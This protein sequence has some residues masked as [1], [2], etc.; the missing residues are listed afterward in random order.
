MAPISEKEREERR[1]NLDKACMFW[2]RPA[3]TVLVKSI[4]KDWPNDPLRWDTDTTLLIRKLAS[5]A[6]D[7]GLEALNCILA[8][9]DRDE[10]GSGIRALHEVIKE[11]VDWLGDPRRNARLWPS[12]QPVKPRQKVP[13]NR[14]RRSN[15]AF[16]EFSLAQGGGGVATEV[17]LAERGG[18]S[19]KEGVGG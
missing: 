5:L 12:P 6:P 3:E 8:H 15:I 7:D 17:Y 11:I 18:Q 13:R 4:R 19:V 16:T 2:K 14:T 9:D 10:K 1:T